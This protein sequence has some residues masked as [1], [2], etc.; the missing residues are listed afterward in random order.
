MKNSLN[1][2]LKEKVIAGIMHI[3]GGFVDNPKDRGG[4]TKYGITMATAVRAGF[5][6]DIRQLPYS[7]AYEVYAD[8]YWNVNML[9]EVAALSFSIAEE[10]ADTG[11]NM[12]PGRAAKYLQR[13][14]NVLNRE[15]KLYDDI[16]VDGKMGIKT[17]FALKT[18]LQYRKEKGEVV[19]KR[20]LNALQVCKY[21]RIA[22]H[23]ESQEEFEFGWVFNRG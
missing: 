4:R 22:E 21:I 11:I 1:S 14:L 7:F 17:I 3:E 6:G 13:S 2:N 16:V 18:F 10:M 19:L 9:D 12:G 5:V 23:D 20:M 8:K 15:E